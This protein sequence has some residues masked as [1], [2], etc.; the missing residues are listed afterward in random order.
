M[1]AVLFLLTSVKVSISCK[2]I[3]SKH[4]KIE[5]LCLYLYQQLIITN[6]KKLSHMIIETFGKNFFDVIFDKQETKESF[7]EFL[8]NANLEVSPE[9]RPINLELIAVSNEYRR[10][11]VRNIGK[12]CYYVGNYLVPLK[13]AKAYGIDIPFASSKGF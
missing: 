8:K 11:D 7:D 2:I 5:K 9:H 6:S 1:F 3:L 4:N 13:I 10:I 12:K